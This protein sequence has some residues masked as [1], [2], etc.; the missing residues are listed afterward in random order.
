VFSEQIP[1]QG[2]D[3]IGVNAHH[4]LTITLSCSMLLNLLYN[5]CKTSSTLGKSCTSDDRNCRSSFLLSSAQDQSS[6][7]QH[8]PLPAKEKKRAQK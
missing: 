3:G 5:R 1:S 2:T 6:L 7:I 4:K 8:F